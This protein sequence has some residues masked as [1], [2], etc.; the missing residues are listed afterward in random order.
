MSSQ[1]E[2]GHV[3]S[4][5]NFYPLNSFE[6]GYGTDYNPSKPTLPLA[7]LSAKHAEADDAVKAVNTSVQP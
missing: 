3:K 5:A 2:T 6:F 7:V 4:V 1:T